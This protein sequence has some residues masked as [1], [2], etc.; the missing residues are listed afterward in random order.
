MLPWHSNQLLRKQT[1][2]RFVIY[3]SLRKNDYLFYF[4]SLVIF[5]NIDLIIRSSSLTHATVIEILRS[6]YI[7]LR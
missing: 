7:T 6:K 5:Y 1:E 4:I 2:R 3:Y